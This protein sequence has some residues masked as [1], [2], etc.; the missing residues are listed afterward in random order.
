MYVLLL[1]SNADD[2]LITEQM[3]QTQTGI[4][5]LLHATVEPDLT[6]SSSPLKP[7]E[8]NVLR[9]QYEKEGSYVGLQT[10][11]NYAWVCYGYSFP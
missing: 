11:F 5:S 1:W 10:K 2:M 7:D 4:Q 8:L 9:S 6:L 3:P